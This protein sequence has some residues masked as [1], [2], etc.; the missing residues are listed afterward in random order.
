MQFTK[1]LLALLPLALSVAG[2]SEI[3]TPWKVS[4]PDNVRNLS[5]DVTTAWAK[6]LCATLTFQV[7]SG[8][9]IVKTPIADGVLGDDGQVWG[10]QVVSL[11]KLLWG[12][13]T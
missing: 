11:H 1:S 4:V 8:F 2:E 7:D 13:V 3:C 6:D 10:L 9:E 5:S 12:Y